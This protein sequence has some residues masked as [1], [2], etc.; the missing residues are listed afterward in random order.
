MNSLLV[1]GNFRF[2]NPLGLIHNNVFKGFEL[3]VNNPVEGFVNSILM[4]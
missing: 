4:V 3:D 2:L 1:S